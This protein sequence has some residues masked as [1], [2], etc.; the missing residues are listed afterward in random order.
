LAIVSDNLQQEEDKRMKKYQIA[1]AAAL[2]VMSVSAPALAG[3]ITVV[4]GTPPPNPIVEV[5][6]VAPG[7]AENYAWHAGHWRWIDEQHVWVPGHWVARPRPTA[8]WVEPKWEQHHDG[9][10][11]SEGRWKD[12]D[13]HEG[14]DNHDSHDGHDGHEGHDDHR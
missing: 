8:V 9:Y 11:F 5:V 3:G 7:P 6:P 14:R 12:H 10:H 1:I 13:D 4:I 2:L